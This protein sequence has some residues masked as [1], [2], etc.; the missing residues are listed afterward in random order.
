MRKSFV[1]AGAVVLGVALVAVT[2]ASGGA[3]ATA[4]SPSCRGDGITVAALAS[5]CAVSS[6][7]V[8]LPDGRRFAVPP[9]GTTVAALPVA[10]SGAV[11]PGDVSVTNTGRSGV[12]V[13]IDDRWA[14]APAAVRLERAALQQRTATTRATA[15]AATSA[16]SASAPSSC[17]N[18]TYTRTGF[19]WGSR[20][21]WRYNA[22]GQKGT[23]SVTAIRA[24][25]DAWTGAL[26]TCGKKVTSTAADRYL[27][28]TTQ[29]SGVTATGGCGTSSGTSVAAWGSLRAGTLAVTCVWSRS[30]VAV[31]V[32]Q[33][34][35]TAAAWSAT[36]TCSGT[37]FDLRGVAT[38][39]WGHAYGLG[40]TAQNSG[41]VMKPAST[42]CETGQRTLGLGDLMG[43]DA[44]Y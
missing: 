36:T 32:D 25:S 7:T 43:I 6:G 40:H 13:R 3:A 19:R 8:V 18:K 5:G 33:R 42:T 27:G 2:V 28:T 10:A 11:D 16:T 34:Y 9:S 31:E 4:A 17:S 41:L 37:K 39:E 26:A 29:A 30:G 15:G 14:G 20:V 44:L 38:H 22:T 12:A 35:T 24:G 21:D 23:G 1:T